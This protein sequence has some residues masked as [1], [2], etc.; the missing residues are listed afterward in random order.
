METIRLDLG[1][2]GPSSFAQE[3]QAIAHHKDP[4]GWDNQLDDEVGLALL[5]EQRYLFAARGTSGWG[6]DFL[7]AAHFSLGNVDTHLGLGVLARGGFN[8]PNEFET[9]LQRTPAQWGAY[10]FAGADG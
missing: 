8:V 10:M 2:V 6:A 4:K 9:T 7:P 5:Y 3:C 1:V